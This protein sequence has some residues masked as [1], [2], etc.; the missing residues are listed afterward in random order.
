[1]RTSINPLDEKKH[2]TRAG[3]LTHHDGTHIV[4]YTSQPMKS[5]EKKKK[6]AKIASLNQTKLTIHK[7]KTYLKIDSSGNIEL[8]VTEISSKYSLK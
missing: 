4:F 8:H 2:F 7:I 3:P 6:I 5:N 1:M